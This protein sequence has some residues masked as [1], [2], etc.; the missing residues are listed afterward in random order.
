M[1]IEHPT[2]PRSDVSPRRPTRIVS[3]IVVLT[4]AA[5]VVLLL[6][7][8]Q[9][10]G[11]QRLPGVAQLIAFRGV[12]A[13]GF[14]VLTVIAGIAALIRRRRR[15]VIALTLAVML[16]AGAAVNGGVLAAR[17]PGSDALPG[18]DLVVMVWNTQGGATTPD[19]IARVAA[20]AHADVVSLPETDE[21]AA[22]EVARLLAEDGIDM[23]PHTV[24]ERWEIPTSLLVA[25][26]LG[27]YRLDRGAGSAPGVPSGVWRKTTGD[28]PATIVAAHPLPPL[29]SMMG[30]WWAGL[31]WIAGVCDS[32]DVVVAGDLNATNDH[33]TG[34]GAEGHLIG[35]CDDAASNAGG[36]A[37]GTWP[38]T[39]PEWIAAPID[40]VLHGLAW[41]SAGVQTPDT[42]SGGSDHRPIVAVLD[43]G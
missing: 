19:E 29:P 15:P 23:T 34:L 27:E 6:S 5:M 13:V 11:A 35:G 36:G 8:P 26:R 41:R 3:S 1:S 37:A 28:G 18:G 25:D 17:G 2:E 38:S 32:P 21:D 16:A 9:A 12:L 4:A 30:E 33:L 24:G 31:E 39:V 42:R 7:W 14:A 20:E 22:A 43:R 40:H 10:V